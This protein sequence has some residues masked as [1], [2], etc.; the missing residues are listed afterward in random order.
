MK[1]KIIL[2]AFAVA[3]IA[4]SAQ[5]QQVIKLEPGLSYTLTNEVSATGTGVTYQWYRNGAAIANAT[6]ATYT[7]PANL[8]NGINVEFKRG[9]KSSSCGSY[10]YANT[11]TITFCLSSLSV[12]N[13]CWADVNVDSYQ[14][15]A[16]RPDMYTKFY[17]WNRSTA[18]SATDPLTPSWNATA[19]TS[20]T[21]T[22]N[23]CPG[24]WR[25]PT[26]G[27]LAELNASGSTWVYAGTRGAAVNG[28]FL[29][30]NHSNSASCKLPS[31][32]TSCIF[33][34]AG[35]Y[36]G[37]NSSN[38]TLSYQGVGGDYYSSTEVNSILAYVLGFNDNDCLFF[39]FGK[40]MGIY[41]RC[42]Q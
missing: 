29:G 39:N 8:A 21:W 42:V 5:A 20:T 7:L 37:G 15:W 26:Q 11:I 27:E 40:E 34:P 32:M 30:L 22:V 17:Q 31:P 4:V 18:Y 41:I 3:A 12:G 36:R 23:P 2:T 33:L 10:S 9:A 19:N 16:A 6:S 28:R 24:N 1:K 38:G 14:Q 13:V 35:G 25:L